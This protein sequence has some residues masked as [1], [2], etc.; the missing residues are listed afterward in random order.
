MQQNYFY[1]AV[2][3]LLVGTAL[4]LLGAPISAVAGLSFL[5]AFVFTVLALYHL[6]KSSLLVLAVVFLI[7]VCT[8]AARGEVAHSPSEATAL[9]PVVG[10]SVVASGTVVSRPST[11][12]GSQTL[13]VRLESAKD[14]STNTEV[15]GPA[16]AVVYAPAYP[17]LNY[18]DQVRLRGRLQKPE[19]FSSDDGRTFAYPQ[20]LARQDIY[21]EINQPGIT[22]TG[23]GGG[24][25]IK[26][27]LAKL[28]N[29]L[30]SAIKGM[31]PKPESGLAGGVLL[32]AEDELGED[33]IADFRAT[34][35]VH[36][37]VLSGFHVT[38]VATAIGK[39]LLLAGLPLAG[40]M[41][42]AGLGI[43]LFVLL[44]GLS[45]TIIRASIMAVF[46]LIARVSG[47]QYAAGRGLGLAVVGMVLV[48]PNILLYDPSFQLSVAATAGLIMF[49]DYISDRLVWIPQRWGLREVATAT[50]SAQLMVLPLILY[51]MG[52]LS[53]VSLPANLLVLPVIPVLMTVAAITAVLGLISSVLG[54]APA[55]FAYLLSGYVI[56]VVRWLANIPGAAVSVPP[57][58][59]WLVFVMY[60][61]I[62]ALYFWLRT[63]N[64]Y[65]KL[66]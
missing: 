24:S 45:P 57:F 15:S 53:L 42:A 46:A 36:V 29:R 32:G 7:G 59:V 28:Q 10:T 14:Q 37:V 34:S 33:M 50:I 25:L 21:Y 66:P 44:V 51:H 64:S 43:I 8:G 17:Q 1:S 55:V 49:G 5:L 9:Q 12:G 52:T 16:K 31:I 39:G 35:V 27:N 11:S 56:G 60:A 38:V 65:A 4:V 13:T 47:R 61:G 23:T 30:L 22:R 62:F 2:L 48:S 19:S 41:L 63:D 54:F 26:R 58:P 18:G 40:A 3:G 20:Y 6:E